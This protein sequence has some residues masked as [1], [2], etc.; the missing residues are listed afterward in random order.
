MTPAERRALFKR[1]PGQMRGHA[2]RPGT[3]P[4]GEKCGTCKHKVCKGGVAG[5]YLKCNL[6]RAQ[7]TGG[8]G[9]DIFARDAAC[10]KW[11]SKNDDS[12]GEIARSS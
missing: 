5:R 12:R 4:A 8:K 9:T 2:G 6:M 11:E 3:G 7:W 1:A 10:D